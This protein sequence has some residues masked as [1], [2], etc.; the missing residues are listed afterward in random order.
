[1]I[2]ID[3]VINNSI[4]I[5]KF[6][7][8]IEESHQISTLVDY[9]NGS[10]NSNDNIIGSHYNYSRKEVESSNGIKYFV[11]PIYS[12]LRRCGVVGVDDCRMSNRI[13]F[14]GESLQEAIEWINNAVG[15]MNV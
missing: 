7:I 4:F 3:K 1:M 5:G 2:Q 6:K 15:D 13:Y 11:L 10:R 8:I 12:E 14:V 9:S